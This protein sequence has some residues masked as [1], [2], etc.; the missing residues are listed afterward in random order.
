MTNRLFIIA[1]N[2][3]E[4]NDFC[5]IAIEKQVYPD[6]YL[7]WVSGPDSLR[8]Y[9]NPSGI[10]TGSWKTRPDIEDILYQLR[11][12]SYEPDKIR[13]VNNLLS[14]V[15]EYKSLGLRPS[16]GANAVIGDIRFNTTT[17][18]MEVYNGNTWVNIRLESRKTVSLDD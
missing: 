13:Q 11:V 6:Y 17:A 15:K 7:A 12:S 18:N 2:K 1:G 16:Q 10:C 14:L 8:G 9:S 5:R 4:Y 3:Q